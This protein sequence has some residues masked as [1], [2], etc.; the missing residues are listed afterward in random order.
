MTRL[1]T[2]GMA[3]LLLAEAFA[4]L[5]FCLGFFWVGGIVPGLVIALACLVLLLLPWLG[6]LVL[7]FDSLPREVKVRL[8]WWARAQVLLGDEKMLRVRLLGLPYRRSLRPREAKPGKPQE[9]KPDLKRWARENARDLSRLALSGLQAGSELFWEAKAFSLTVNAPAQAD[10]V[11]QIVAGLI[12]RRKAHVFELRVL[13]EGPPAECARSTASACCRWPRSACSCLPRGG[14]SR[15]PDPWAA[16]PS[17]RRPPHSLAPLRRRRETRPASNP[18]AMSTPPPRARGDVQVEVELRRQLQAQGRIT[19]ADYM[20]IALYLPEGGYYESRVVLGRQGDFLTS[21]ETHP[22][23]GALLARLLRRQWHALGQPARFEVVEYGAG[24]GSLCRQI[25]TA[26][27]TLGPGFADSLR[28][29]I[30]E[31]S[32]YL[33]AEQHAR[34]LDLSGLVT[35]EPPGPREALA[36]GCVLAN[37]VVDVLPVHRVTLEGGRLRELYVGE[38]AGRLVEMAGP[39]S[40]LDLEEYLRR[41]GTRLPEGAVAE[42]C[43]QARPWL[44]EAASRLARG[45]LLLLDYGGPASGLYNEATPR[46]SSS[47]STATAGPKI[48]TTDPAYRTSPPRWTS[49]TWRSWAGRPGWRSVRN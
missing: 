42:V 14:Y 41:V 27:A 25:I 21:P 28:Y 45:Y 8:A 6:D 10:V 46:D 38:V 4:A 29:T 32:S 2:A 16:P 36:F 31:T 37:E 33:R 19:F 7:E 13:P 24:T 20:A 30:I 47:A 40:T 11:D 15:W 35:W 48:P 26:S 18:F 12:G 17:R 44:A 22:V 3:L 5:G 9:P 39:L 23:S 43:L 1:Y 34:L 49:P